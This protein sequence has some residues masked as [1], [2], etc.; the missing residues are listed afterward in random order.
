MGF[1]SR[2]PIA[3]A[4]CTVPGVVGFKYKPRAAKIGDAWPTWGGD[5]HV[6]PGAY[7]TRWTVMILMPLDDA[8]QEEWIETHRD[9]LVEAL[10]DAVWVDEIAPGLSG[11][12]PVLMLTCRE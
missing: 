2:Q 10:A 5:T 6:S 7:E 12:S 11:D 3:D 9:A 1:E 8:G 4:L